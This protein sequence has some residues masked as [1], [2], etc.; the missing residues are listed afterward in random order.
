MARV[1]LME[2][3]AEIVEAGFINNFVSIPPTPPTSLDYHGHCLKLHCTDCKAVP[4]GTFC[5]F[6][7]PNSIHDCDQNTILLM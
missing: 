4:V 6:L 2:G 5:S 7:I 3:Y 1:K